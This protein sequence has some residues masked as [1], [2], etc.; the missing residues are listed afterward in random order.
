MDLEDL[1]PGLLVR[2][3]PPHPYAGSFGRIIEIGTFDTL[4][5]GKRTGA[6]VDIGQ[7]GLLIVSPEYLEQVE[8]G[9]LPPGWEEF[10][11]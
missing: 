7:S 3:L 10:E 11:V 8:S 9:L 5:E 1:R 2:I 4:L 6:K